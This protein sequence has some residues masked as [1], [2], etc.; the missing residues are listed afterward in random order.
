MYLLFLTLPVD[1]SEGGQSK[2]FGA[3]VS[4]VLRSESDVAKYVDFN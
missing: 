1:N 3:L 2:R 4:R